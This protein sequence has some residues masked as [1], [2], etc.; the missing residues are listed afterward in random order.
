MADIN[1]DLNAIREVIETTLSRILEERGKIEAMG[2]SFEAT[3]LAS[4]KASAEAKLA[5][6]KSENTL[7]ELDE[8][9]EIIKNSVTLVTEK[10]ESSKDAAKISQDAKKAVEA[11][12]NQMQAVK[13]EICQVKAEVKRASENVS[14]AVAA[15]NTTSKIAIMVDNDA[16]EVKKDREVVEG[17]MKALMEILGNH[18][19]AGCQGNQNSGCQKPSGA[20]NAGNSCDPKDILSELD[21]VMAKIRLGKAP[22]AGAKCSTVAGAKCSIER[23]GKKIELPTISEA[24]TEEELAEFIKKLKEKISGDSRDTGNTGN[25]NSRNSGGTGSAGNIGDLKDR[26]EKEIGKAGIDGVIEDLKGPIEIIP[27]PQKP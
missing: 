18:R 4:E 3:K 8:A 10:N 19:N 16:K 11:I 20:Q 5:I 24:K 23:A 14:L 6:L 15:A 12:L 1:Q 22:V 26:V 25:Q 21:K 27:D 13:A 2:S 9:L 17:L 7:T